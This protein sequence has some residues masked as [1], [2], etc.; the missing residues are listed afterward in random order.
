MSDHY[1]R[2]GLP[3]RFSVDAADV[4]RRY[5]ALSRQSHPDFHGGASDADQ[6]AAIAQTASLNQ[7]YAT[8]KDPF[9][10]AEYLLSLLGGPTA[11]QEKGQDQAFLMQMM[12]TRERMDDVRAA[13]G[14]LTEL[15][16]D[17][18]GQYESILADVGTRFAKLEA[19]TAPPADALLGIR[20]QL[21]AAR[22]IQS[23]LRDLRGTPDRG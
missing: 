14:D 6:M 5:L 4:E 12:E 10:R 19:E 1:E 7:A 23:L 17:L 22:T 11:G 20:R 2:L 3:R 13:G 8:L 16:A 18:V 21:N 15:E 9:R